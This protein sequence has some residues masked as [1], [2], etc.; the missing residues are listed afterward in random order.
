MCGLNLMLMCGV[1][2]IRQGGDVLFSCVVTVDDPICQVLRT[3]FNGWQIETPLRAGPY[4]TLAGFRTPD[5]SISMF[6]R[7]VIFWPRQLYRRARV[8][9]LAVENGWKKTISIVATFTHVRE[10]LCLCEL[11]SVHTCGIFILLE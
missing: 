4:G 3:S 11:V 8:V 9:G 1:S 6:V 5:V 10:R 7:E 2:V